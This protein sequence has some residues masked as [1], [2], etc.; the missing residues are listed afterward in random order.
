MALSGQYSTYLERSVDA[1][2]SIPCDIQRLLSTI[3]DLDVRVAELK[4]QGQS[5]CEHICQQPSAASRQATAEQVAHV[6]SL[7][8][9]M[10]KD[11]KN[12]T[13]LANEK[14]FLTNQALNMIG[15]HV[16]RMDAELAEFKTELVITEPTLQFDDF[17]GFVNGDQDGPEESLLGGG[18]CTIKYNKMT[19]AFAYFAFQGWFEF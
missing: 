19:E 9:Q 7:R 12:L 17:G 5:Q 6:A 15:G 18:E 11:Q 10:E 2:I 14:I 4:A 13:F 1:A 3:K 8:E 16:K